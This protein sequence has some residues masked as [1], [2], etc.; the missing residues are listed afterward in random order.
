MDEHENSVVVRVTNAPEPCDGF[1]T[2]TIEIP[3]LVPAQGGPAYRRVAIQPDA[4]DWQTMRTS[5]DSIRCS[6]NKPSPGGAR[7]TWSSKRSK[8][9]T[10]EP[11]VNAKRT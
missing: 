7:T 5:P 2:R 3:P 8:T 10:S 1:G 4:L 11:D 6:T 9:S